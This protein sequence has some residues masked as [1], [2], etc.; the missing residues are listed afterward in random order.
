MI[1]IKGLIEISRRPHRNAVSTIASATKE[2][3]GLTEARRLRIS[4][5][6]LREISGPEFPGLHSASEQLIS[7]F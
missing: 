3:G 6:V 7:P 1:R 5:C 2:G 4:S